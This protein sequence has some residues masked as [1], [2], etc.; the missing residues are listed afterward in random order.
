MAGGQPLK[1]YAEVFSDAGNTPWIDVIYVDT[2]KQREG[3][4]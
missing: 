2:V 1:V 3:E 4:G